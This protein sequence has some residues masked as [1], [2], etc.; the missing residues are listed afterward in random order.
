MRWGG[1]YVLHGADIGFL[2]PKFCKCTGGAKGIIENGERRKTPCD[3][4]RIDLPK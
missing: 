2:E 1:S 3:S 4:I